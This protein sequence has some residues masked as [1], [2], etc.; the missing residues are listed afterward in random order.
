MSKLRGQD[1]LADAE[2]HAPSVGYPPVGARSHH[3]IHQVQD[4][5]CQDAD[6][7]RKVLDLQLLQGVSQGAQLQSD[8]V[9]LI[10]SGPACGSAQHLSHQEHASKHET[11]IS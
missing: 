10:A 7:I 8:T 1:P 11:Q 4:E 2:Q 9:R 3:H 5:R 6:L